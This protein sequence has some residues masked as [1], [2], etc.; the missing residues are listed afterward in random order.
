MSQ[1][2]HMA[3]SETCSE[4]K[5]ARSDN[6]A[7]QCRRFAPAPLGAVAVKGEGGFSRLSQASW[8]YVEADDW[9]GEFAKRRSGGA[10]AV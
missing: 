7:L 5:F 9:C 3:Q 8:P 4:C 1:N 6:D 10:F 2:G